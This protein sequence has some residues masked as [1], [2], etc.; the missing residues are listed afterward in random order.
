MIGAL[1]VTHGGVAGELLRAATTIEGALS[2]VSALSLDWNEDPSSAAELL[3]KAVT[4]A[5]QGDGVVILTDMFGGTP[6]NLALRLLHEGAVEVVSGVNLPMV[7]KLSLRDQPGMTIPELARRLRDKGR[8][9]IEV[10]SEVL[11]SPTRPRPT[12]PEVP[13]L[14]AASREGR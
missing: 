9:S 14:P 4:E 12:G 1:I 10:A 3:S 13:P 6:T 2:A 11:K 8:K 7:L 5:D